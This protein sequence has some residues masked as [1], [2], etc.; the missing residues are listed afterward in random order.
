MS[1]KPADMMAL[2][3]IWSSLWCLL[4]SAMV[5]VQSVCAAPSIRFSPGF[6]WSDGV[7]AAGS[8]DG[9][10]NC[11]MY[12]DSYFPSLMEPERLINLFRSWM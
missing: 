8:R 3:V 12:V 9:L 7:L 6:G 1:H 10:L 2:S 11:L 4:M 5:S